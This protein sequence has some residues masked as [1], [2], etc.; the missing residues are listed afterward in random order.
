MFSS[1]PHPLRRPGVGSQQLVWQRSDVLMT[2]QTAQFTVVWWS[3]VAR[4]S[5]GTTHLWVFAAGIVCCQLLEPPIAD[6]CGESASAAFGTFPDLHG[7]KWA[8]GTCYQNEYLLL[9]LSGDC[10]RCAQKQSLNILSI[11]TFFQR[12]NVLLKILVR[13]KS[14]LNEPSSSNGGQCTFSVSVLCPRWM[15]EVALPAQPSI[16]GGWIR[17]QR[18]IVKISTLSRLFC[19][20]SHLSRAHERAF[21]SCL[22]L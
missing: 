20:V 1:F 21:A 11:C 6:V 15:G 22:H 7:Q 18:S 4:R 5:G 3:V 2:W 19:S 9:H 12:N 17:G 14:S 8:V 13:G 10:Q 16:T